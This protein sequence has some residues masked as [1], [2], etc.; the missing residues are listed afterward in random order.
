MEKKGLENKTKNFGIQI[1]RAVLCLWIV[2]GHCSKIKETH[3]TYLN[4]RFHVPTFLLISFFFITISSL[5][6]KYHGLF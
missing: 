6:R 1:L 5:K 3:K 2:I 4:K